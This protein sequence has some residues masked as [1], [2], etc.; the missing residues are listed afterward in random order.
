MCKNKLF[1][2]RAWGSEPVPRAPA[3]RAARGAAWLGFEVRVVHLR[4]ST[5][6][7]ISGQGD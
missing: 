1:T 6:H 7:A 5:C 2:C 3:G 4:R